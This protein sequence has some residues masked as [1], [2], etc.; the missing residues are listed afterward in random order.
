MLCSEGQG[1]PPS[2]LRCRSVERELPGGS[3]TELQNRWCDLRSRR[4][5]GCSDI[6]GRSATRSSVQCRDGGGNVDGFAADATQICGA[7][8]PESS[9]CD[10]WSESSESRTA[11]FS[12]G[13]LR[14]H[15]TNRS[16]VSWVQRSK[17]TSW[18]YCTCRRWRTGHMCAW[19]MRASR[20]MMDTIRTWEQRNQLRRCD[21]GFGDGVEPVDVPGRLRGDCHASSAFWQSSGLLGSSI[22]FGRG[23]KCWG[24]RGKNNRSGADVPLCP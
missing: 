19:M 10:A 13:V 15:L 12:R 5:D 6:I 20:P 14:S 3:Y 4:D 7:E 9:S 21:G 24:S 18:L 11:L 16:M 1:T 23:L 22:R 17:S 8:S 2:R